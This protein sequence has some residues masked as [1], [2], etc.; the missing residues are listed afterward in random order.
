MP[1]CLLFTSRQNIK[2]NQKTKYSSMWTLFQYLIYWRSLPPVWHNAA[3]PEWVFWTCCCT[4]HQTTCQ[5]IFLVAA[6]TSSQVKLIPLICISWE[7]QTTKKSDS[8]K[9]GQYT[10]Y[11]KTSIPMHAIAAEVS[12]S[13]MFLNKFIKSLPVKTVSCGNRPSRLRLVI[14]VQISGT[15]LDFFTQL[16]IVL[17]FTV[18]SPQ[19][20]DGSFII[21]PQKLSNFRLF[22]EDMVENELSILDQIQHNPLSFTSCTLWQTTVQGTGNK[23]GQVLLRGHMTCTRY[24][25][26]VLLSNEPWTRLMTSHSIIPHL[27]IFVMLVWSEVLTT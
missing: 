4:T 2:M 22:D 3:S 20:S 11:G 1:P 17:M 10:G 12:N 25:A 14:Q 15:I 16:H 13:I 19:S 23:L 9:S 7:Q 24:L 6:W 27:R 18:S 5:N 26:K 21:V 8:A